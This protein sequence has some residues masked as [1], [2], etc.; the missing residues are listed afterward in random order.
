M[1]SKDQERK[2][3]EQIRKIVNALGEGSYIAMAFEGCFEIAEDN[4]GND[5]GCSMKQRLDAAEVKLNDAEEKLEAA[6]II[7]A[8]IE[9]EKIRLCEK[10]QEQQRQLERMSEKANKNHENYAKL[11]NQFRAT[12][13]KLEAA[14]QEIIGL[15]ARLYDLLAPKLADLIAKGE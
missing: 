5:F 11:W 2:A 7:R 13:D 14:Q 8:N 1:T 6:G 10:V 4:I 3:L 9:K 15:K 12:E